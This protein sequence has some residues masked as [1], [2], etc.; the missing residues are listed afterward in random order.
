MD[1]QTG[2]AAEERKALMDF[3]SCFVLLSWTPDP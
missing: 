2:P 3:G 1:E